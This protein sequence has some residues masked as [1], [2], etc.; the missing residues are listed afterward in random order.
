MMYVSVYVYAKKTVDSCG[1]NGISN[2]KKNDY[3]TGGFYQENCHLYIL[4]PV[5]F[6]TMGVVNS[7]P[8]A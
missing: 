4:I 3:P 7:H 8:G 6:P 1:F 5:D 2:G